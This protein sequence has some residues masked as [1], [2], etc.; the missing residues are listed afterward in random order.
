MI[1]YEITRFIRGSLYGMLS[2]GVVKFYVIQRR[3]GVIRYI[4]RLAALYP[5]FVL[6]WESTLFLG[7]LRQ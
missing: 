4:I 6:S 5:C 3:Y 2:R 7:A 1:T